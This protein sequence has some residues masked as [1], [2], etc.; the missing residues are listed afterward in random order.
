LW[1]RNAWEWAAG[2]GA[3]LLSV[4]C[5][6]A[7]AGRLLQVL[8]GGVD[9]A[10]VGVV[11]ILVGIPKAPAE[12]GSRLLAVAQF[13]LLFLAAVDALG[14]VFDAR[15]RPLPWPVIAA[16]ALLLLALAWLGDRL[17]AAARE[18]KLLAA[19]CAVCAVLVA[20]LEGPANTQALL[21]A[22]LLLA[23]AGASGWPHRAAPGVPGTAVRNSASPA[24]S[25]AGAAQRVE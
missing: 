20:F 16:P 17:P 7:A 18:E 19:V 22:A 21:Y 2:G 4:I 13:G 14:L 6:A 25:A 8:E 12:T 15:Y 9:R 1:S 3:L 10:R 23:L 11:G 24:S 5:G